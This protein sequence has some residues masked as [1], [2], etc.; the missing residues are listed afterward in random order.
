MQIAATKPKAYVEGSVLMWELGTLQ[1]K[2]D[3]N[4]Q[5]RLVPES[6]ADLGCRAWVTFTG[7]TAMQVRVREPKLLLKTA[8]P[9]KVLIGDA[10]SFVLT[11]SNPGDGPVDAR[12]CRTKGFT[13]SKVCGLNVC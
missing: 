10:A 11:A 12:S 3:M 2:Q 9:S 8:A 1:P 7:A 4:L 13:D 6:K 5:V